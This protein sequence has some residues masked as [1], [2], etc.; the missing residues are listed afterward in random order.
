MQCGEGLSISQLEELESWAGNCSDDISDISC[1]RNRKA[2][3]NVHLGPNQKVKKMPYAKMPNF[4][5]DDRAE[6]ERENTG[7]DLL[8][9][10]VRENEVV[11][12]FRKG[13]VY[14]TRAILPRRGE[15]E[16]D[17]LNQGRSAI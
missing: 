4:L 14:I 13:S 9:R 11:N 7:M 2:T 3:D 17:G 16:F 1:E 8:T 6:K 15:F 12:S 5:S 10:K